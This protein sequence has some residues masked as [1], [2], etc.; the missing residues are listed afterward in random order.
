MKIK[1][2]TPAP[3]IVDPSSGSLT[4]PKEKVEQLALAHLAVNIGREVRQRD[5]AE[6]ALP[7]ELY[8]SIDEVIGLKSNRDRVSGA[9]SWIRATLG[10]DRVPKNLRHADHTFYKLEGERSEVDAFE[11]LESRA[12][13]ERAL[14]G[15]ERSVDARSALTAAEHGISLW[16][17]PLDFQYFTKTQ[18][19]VGLKARLSA[20]M[21]D[22]FGVFAQSAT[23]LG[24]END[25]IRFLEERLSHLPEF[26]VPIGRALAKLYA[27]TG[28]RRRAEELVAT[29]EAR[30]AAEGLSE[31]LG[32]DSK[33]N[34]PL[35]GSPIR[36]D[37]LTRSMPPGIQ[38]RIIQL[39][40]ANRAQ[41][42]LMQLLRSVQVHQ[43]FRLY[44]VSGVSAAGKDTLVSGAKEDASIAE[45][46]E[47]L[48][49][50]TTRPGRT[51]EES[52]SRSLEWQEFVQFVEDGKIIFVY[53]KRQ[54][55][56]G[57]DLQQFKDAIKRGTKLVAIF[58]EFDQ[59][60]EVRLLLNKFGIQV[61]PIFVQ[62]DYPTAA[63]RTRLRQFSAQERQERIE[64]IIEDFGR[65]LERPIDQEYVVIPHT[66]D[67]GYNSAL[68]T[69][70]MLL[71][72]SHPELERFKAI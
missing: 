52:Y 62:A 45:R 47:V 40:P 5:L 4:T 64:S 17:G 42:A 54:Q 3:G 7:E 32:L 58:T 50:Y 10:E 55:L 26:D 23:Q 38:S 33:T 24:E 22:L 66:N 14:G 16:V 67:F 30:G 28:D 35:A 39:D 43:E 60:P 69:L 71:D 34:N 57:F 8:R 19:G 20:A 63:R 1:I 72:G 49:K 46:F 11:L 13:A 70:K 18:Q 36:G 15:G 6:A 65:M 2:L 53:E 37:S 29:L 48:T 31:E 68:E 51:N 27:Q 25:G 12:H 41:G 44:I 9:V 56:Y 61:I 21:V 59:V